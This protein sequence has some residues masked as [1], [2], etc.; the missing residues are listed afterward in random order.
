VVNPA[1]TSCP[2]S[3]IESW[4]RP[5]SRRWTTRAGNADDRAGARA[6]PGDERFLGAADQAKPTN[7]GNVDGCQSNQQPEGGRRQRTPDDYVCQTSFERRGRYV[8]GNDQNE[9][10]PVIPYRLEIRVQ[11]CQCGGRQI[12]GEHR[13][14]CDRAVF[15][16]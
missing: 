11:G 5:T 10:G 3:Q 12:A 4:R 14:H 8:V 15:G 1:S 6:S 9:R 2:A 13:P 16:P 7:V